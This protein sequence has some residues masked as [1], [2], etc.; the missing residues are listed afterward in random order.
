MSLGTSS[1]IL[2][3][4]LI[5]GEGKVASSVLLVKSV[6]MLGLHRDGLESVTQRIVDLLASTQNAIDPD[7]VTRFALEYRWQWIFDSLHQSEAFLDDYLYPRMNRRHAL[8]A[9]GHDVTRRNVHL[10]RELMFESD[11]AALR[12][13]PVVHAASSK[14]LPFFF[15]SNDE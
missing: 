7:G 8:E 11:L 13:R 6:V 15:R 2:H 10:L 9:P 5:Y 12:S 3:G 1:E 14:P 4:R